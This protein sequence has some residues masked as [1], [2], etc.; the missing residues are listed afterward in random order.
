MPGPGET[1]QMSPYGVFHIT[2]AQRWL[3]VGA[4]PMFSVP[5]ATSYAALT[6]PA[7]SSIT[8]LGYIDTGSARWYEE[9]PPSGTGWVQSTHLKPA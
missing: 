6:H 7:G 9:G 1:V 8:T 2:D 5:D 3:A 4:T